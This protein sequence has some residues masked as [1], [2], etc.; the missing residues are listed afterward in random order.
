MKILIDLDG[1]L[2]H[3][4]DIAFNEI[5]YGRNQTFQT[6]EIPVIEDAKNFIER[7]KALGH[8]IIIVSDSHHA[9]VN[10]LAKEVFCVDH[11]S[12][13]DKPNTSKLNEF[14]R[15]NFDFREGSEKDYLLVGDS[16][17]DIYLARALGIA[18]VLLDF[19][20]LEEGNVRAL[21]RAR[22]T[23]IKYG[24]TYYCKSYEEV[25]GVVENPITQLLTLEHKSG[26]Q[27]VRFLNERNKNGGLTMFRGLARQSQGLCDTH[28]ALKR[29]YAFQN[30]NRSEA[31]LQDISRDV[32][33]YIS[34]LVSKNSKAHPWD[35]ITCVA[36]K[37]TTRPPRKMEAFLDALDV[38]TEK[39]NLFSWSDKVSGSIRQHKDTSSRYKFVDEFVSV[40]SDVDLKGKNVIVLD[41][42]YT[43]GATADCLSAKLIDAGARSILFVALFYLAD[44]VG[45]DV[46]CPRCGKDAKIKLRKSDGGRFYSCPPPEYG[47]SGCGWMK[48]L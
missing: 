9:Y 17:L 1:T 18:S 42:Q 4:N 38:P 3:T 11:L 31:F 2:T 20:A 32:S 23:R 43:T 14:L 22:A 40:I 10:R 36:D 21:Y 39:V 44:D 7:L 19:S 12:L 27:T 48:N 33:R 47:G 46:K 13:A 45:P 35:Y 6:S 5:K 41:D 16:K 34:E 30:Q 25:I 26:G 29:Y 8:T 37:T 24:S 15:K 28:G